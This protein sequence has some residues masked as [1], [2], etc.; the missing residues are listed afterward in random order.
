MSEVTVWHLQTVAPSELKAKPPV[1]GI[2]VE[3]AQSKQWLLN[4]FLYQLVGGPW[5]WFDKLSWTD[6]QWQNY[7]EAEELRTW[8]ALEGGSPAGYFELQMQAGNTVEIC[9]FGLG[10]SF[11]GRGLGGHL[12]SRAI[13]EAWNWGA[14]RII[15]NTCSLD[16]AGALANYQ[17]R[18]M[19]IYQTERRA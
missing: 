19:S 18:G 2:H 10:S 15:V 5:Q 12:L 13:E 9:Y 6:E 14:E 7:A 17:A 3:E 16:H 1:A 11:I 8:V 4:R